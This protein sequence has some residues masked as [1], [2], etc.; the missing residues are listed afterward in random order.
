MLQ[1]Y[2][3]YYNAMHQGSEGNHARQRELLVSAYN[4]FAD[5]IDIVIA[6]YHVKEAD[7]TWRRETLERLEAMVQQTRGRTGR[8]PQAVPGDEQ[9]RP[10][11]P[12]S[13]P[14]ST[15]K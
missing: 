2:V 3:D 4:G 11:R 15:K 5:N 7:E 14:V 12:S 9:S 6:M 1:S 13:D 10:S 8:V